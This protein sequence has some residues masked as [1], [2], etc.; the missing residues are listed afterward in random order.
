MKNLLTVLAVIVLVALCLPAQAKTTRITSE[1]TVIHFPTMGYAFPLDKEGG[2]DLYFGGGFGWEFEK[3]AF[4]LE[5]KLKNPTF[6]GDQVYL[7]GLSLERI[8][9]K[10]LGMS[11]RFGGSGGKIIQT[12][13]G[14]YDSHE[15]TYGHSHYDRDKEGPM[16]VSAHA[17]LEAGIFRV[18]GE[19]LPFQARSDGS[20][21]GT[22]WVASAGF[23]HRF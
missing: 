11:F 8:V 20:Y 4:F 7:V 17:A 16:Y 5:A 21:S 22:S 1:H 3:F 12:R 15:Q 19:F 9:P 23:A 6:S 10:F 13:E 18:K 14:V 2:N